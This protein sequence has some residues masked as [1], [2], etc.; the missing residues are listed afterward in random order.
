[1]QQDML[2]SSIPALP[3]QPV[4]TP[5]W[6]GYN[7]QVSIFRVKK[8]QLGQMDTELYPPGQNPSYYNPWVTMPYPLLPA[9]NTPQYGG[10]W[11]TA[12][13]RKEPQ[14]H[15]QHGGWVQA[16]LGNKVDTDRSTVAE[17]LQDDVSKWYYGQIN[18]WF[19]YFYEIVSNS[20]RR[21]VSGIDLRSVRRTQT[22]SQIFGNVVILILETGSFEFSVRPEEADG[23]CSAITAAI[24]ASKSRET[25]PM[26]SGSLGKP[27]NASPQQSSNSLS[28][29]GLYPQM[30]LRHSW[31]A[32]VKAV[33]QGQP[34]PIE[35]FE[36]I[37]MLYD[38]DGNEALS[39]QEIRTMLMDLL[40][41]R[42]AEV[43]RA[44]ER[45]V[46]QRC[47]ADALDFKMQ[48]QL[49]VAALNAS[50]LGKD[51]LSDYEGRLGGSGFE[52]QCLLL[53][54][55]LDLSADQWVALPEFLSAA[56]RVLLPES[57]LKQEAHFY[58]SISLVLKL[59]QKA[60]FFSAQGDAECDDSGI[61]VHQ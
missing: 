51:L 44:L 21:R 41:M 35:A 4:P 14:H 6:A 20:N 30:Q 39:L 42:K 16:R 8:Q 33:S 2:P 53:Q 59:I 32:C 27:G 26:S 43:E 18:G 10:P 12:V 23:W 47:N 5:P 48:S 24:L 54:S 60:Q 52:T 11:K 37:F 36:D 56:P 1:M 40:Q 50:A 57:E 55:Q 61:C 7:T 29:S 22:V 9:P 3:L 15:I 28:P 13:A 46:Q 38:V 45:Q 17:K 25:K 58:K 49:K 34:A 31:A 19:L